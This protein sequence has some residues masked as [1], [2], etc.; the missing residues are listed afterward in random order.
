MVE[1]GA[2]IPVSEV[3]RPHAK[4]DHIILTNKSGR[5]IDKRIHYIKS[6]VGRALLF[7]R[8]LFIGDVESIQLNG[9]W[10]VFCCFK[11]PDSILSLEANIPKIQ[12]YIP[13]SS[14]KLCNPHVISDGYTRVEYIAC[15]K[16][17]E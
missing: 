15:V 4:M 1:D 5:W 7:E 3:S 6:K 8:K 12:T 16:P 11:E 9:R 14:S 10:E 13:C 17:P 2:G